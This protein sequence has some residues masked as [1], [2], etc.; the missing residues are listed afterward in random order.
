MSDTNQHERGEERG[1]KGRG[2]HPENGAVVGDG[3]EGLSATCGCATCGSRC[4]RRNG[5]R[6]RFRRPR[7]DSLRGEGE[8]DAADLAAAFDLSGTAPGDGGEQRRATAEGE[9]RERE[10]LP[11]SGY[12]GRKNGEGNEWGAGGYDGGLLILQGS[13]AVT[14]GASEHRA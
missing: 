1:S 4:R 9:A 12:F 10:R 3:G 14:S 7:P 2:A 8:E 6:R 11:R 5:C 13:A